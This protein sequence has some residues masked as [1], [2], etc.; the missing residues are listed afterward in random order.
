MQITH[1]ASDLASLLTADTLS[2]I[3]S[4]HNIAFQSGSLSVQDVEQEHMAS[5]LAQCVSIVV[6]LLLQDVPWAANPLAL[7][8]GISLFTAPLQLVEIHVLQ[9]RNPFQTH[10]VFCIFFFSQMLHF[11]PS[12]VFPISSL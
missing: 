6:A 4:L 5:F 12:Q 7:T 2:A 1:S 9:R 11:A 3:Q 10:S 8:P